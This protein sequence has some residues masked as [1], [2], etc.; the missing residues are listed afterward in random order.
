MTLGIIGCG[1][2]G[3]AILRAV[4]KKELYNK[5]EIYPS[6]KN[7]TICASLKEEGFVHAGCSN[8]ESASCD[9]LL[10]AVKPQMLED[11]VKGIKDGMDMKKTLIISIAPGFTLAML[12]E[13]FGKD[14]MTVRAMPNTPAL[15]GRGVTAVCAGK[16]TGAERFRQAEALFSCCGSV[17]IIPEKLFDAVVGVSGSAPAYVF[18]FID[19]LADAGVRY[20]MSKAQALRF[21][22]QAVAGSAELAIVT[23]RH[24]D[25]LKDMVCSPA[26]T[27][28]EAV[29]VLEKSGLRS[30]VIEGASA[31]AEKSAVMGNLKK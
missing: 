20:G 29:A 15:V 19:A 1:N 13:M 7:E 10:I 16:N 5:A 14:A 21:A 12:D 27:T 8:A 18:M 30:A 6:E 11:T 22:E 24:P 26:G 28:I 4:A 3:G 2:M 25:D 31:A 17:E 23:G 9:V